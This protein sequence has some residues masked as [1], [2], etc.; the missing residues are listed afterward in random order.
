MENSLFD[1][2][3]SAECVVLHFPEVGTPEAA[4]PE[5]AAEEEAQELLHAQWQAQKDAAMRE[6]MQLAC[7]EAADAAR[8]EAEAR[9]H[10]TLE[11]ERSALS[12]ACASFAKA[13]EK[14][15]A[16]V[17][18][19]VVKLSLAIAARVLQ[20]EVKMD[21]TLLMGVVRVALSKLS[22]PEGAVLCV[23]QDQAELWRRA[24]R[25]H[26]VAVDGD[27][28]LEA[29]EMQLRASAGVVE[30]GVAAQLEEI[31]RG[32][33]DLLSKRPA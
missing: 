1:A 11:A 18:E 16:T 8:H 9:F 22:D 27:A 21:P 25:P 6:Q 19:E 15:F 30:L 12:V 23:A 5:C 7:E 13:R 14:Y 24:M 10:N 28:R 20:R 17:E 2:S 3:A 26:G 29:G 33:F 31:E 32:F 4:E